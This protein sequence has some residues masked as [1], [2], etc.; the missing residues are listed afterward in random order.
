MIIQFI[1]S[2]LR[3]LFGTQTSPLP[4]L[5]MEAVKLR[6]EIAAAKKA[7]KRYSHLERQ[8]LGVMA[9]IVAVER[10]IPYRNGSLDWGR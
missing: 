1:I 5:N 6:K 8:L 3:R 2:K 7:K 4:E 10:G 9:K